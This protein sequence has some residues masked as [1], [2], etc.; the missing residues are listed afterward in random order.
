MTLNLKQRL[1]LFLLLVFPLSWYP[2][3][4]ALSRGTTT[5]PNPLGP[6]V[7]GLIVTALSEG[8]PG[9]KAF[10]ARIVRW[11]VGIRWYAFAFLTPFLIPATAGA[12]NLIFGGTLQQPQQPVA[13]ADLIEKFT[14]IFLFIG[15]GEEPGWRGFGVEQLQKVFSP[16]V[17]SLIIWVVWAVWHIPLFG[18]EVMPVIIPAFIIGV[19]AGSIIQTW[20]YNRTRGSVF[21]QMLYH[22][23]VNT[24]G[25]SLIF[26]FF[27]KSDQI[28]L[29]YVYSFL[30][31]SV[32]LAIVVIERNYF[33]SVGYQTAP[34]PN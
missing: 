8:R 27:N 10:F 23:A 28:L 25:S 21:L 2:W 7:A 34:A 19:L 32:A 4:I 14:F 1:I 30:W 9:V 15:L 11:R 5:G 13:P 29:W 24:F 22:S 16:I 20:M 12:I 3:V 17:T 33:R 6:L 26:Q 18:S 31:L